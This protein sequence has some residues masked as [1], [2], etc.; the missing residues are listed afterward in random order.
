MLL[1]RQ[2]PLPAGGQETGLELELDLALF[3]PVSGSE[4]PVA[5]LP[6]STP[7]TR[8][9]AAG[10]QGLPEPGPEPVTTA[11]SGLEAKTDIL[12]EPEPEPEPEPE[13]DQNPKAEPEPEP[14]VE[15]NPEAEPE[16]EDVFSD[17]K[18]SRDDARGPATCPAVPSMTR[19]GQQ[20][21]TMLWVNP[22]LAPK[23]PRRVKRAVQCYLRPCCLIFFLFLGNK[24]E[25]R[26]KCFLAPL[27][28]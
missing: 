3:A 26:K 25:C 19:T 6:G 28:C 22:H 14:V 12:S 15:Q 13:A 17:L 2:P 24:N 4:T 9:S 18:Y 11:M 20:G 8:E 7:S 23:D 1:G 5:R 21:P 10:A 16:P 27:C